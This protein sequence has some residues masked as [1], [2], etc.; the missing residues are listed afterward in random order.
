MQ[1]SWSRLLPRERERERERG[2]GVEWEGIRKWEKL[3]AVILLQIC[4]SAIKI[5]GIIIFNCQLFK[6]NFSYYYHL[7]SQFFFFFKF[8][9]SIIFC[10]SRERFLIY[11]IHYIRYFNPYNTNFF[12]IL[13]K[14]NI[15]ASHCSKH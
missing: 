4:I 14:T 13:I 11:L 5:Q 7:D 10:P 12:D 1:S 8:F 15:M 9:S 6:C 3:L 2:G